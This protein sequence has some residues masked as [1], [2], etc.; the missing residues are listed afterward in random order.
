MIRYLKV[1]I[2]LSL[3]PYTLDDRDHLK[4]WILHPNLNGYDP[5]KH[6]VQSLK[7]LPLINIESYSKVQTV[8]RYYPCDMFYIIYKRY[9]TNTWKAFKLSLIWRTLKVNDF[10]KTLSKT[11]ITISKRQWKTQIRLLSII[12][13]NNIKHILMLLIEIP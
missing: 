10:R 4:F 3:A 2:V 9:L 13:S 7:L 1:T 8:L 11:K 6:K 5:P 12:T